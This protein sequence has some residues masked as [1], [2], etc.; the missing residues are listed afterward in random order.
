MLITYKGVTRKVPD[1]YVP[2]SLTETQRKKQ[3]KS[4]FEGTDRPIFKDRRKRR[5]SW[6]IK[7]NE[8][9]GDDIKKQG[10]KKNLKTISI[11]TKIPLKALQ[12]IFNKGKAAYYTS[13]SRPG[14]TANSWAYGRIYA[15]IM[16]G[17]KIRKIEQHITNKY[18][19]KFNK[20]K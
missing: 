15:Y 5:S 12:E 17:T 4:I 13:G 11:V 6:T 7:F 14:Q 8:R 18:K 20:I 2:K 16:G 19:V 9:Y 10:G 3:I 1:R